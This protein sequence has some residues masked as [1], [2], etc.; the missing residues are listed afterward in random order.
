MRTLLLAGLFV[1]M[2]LAGCTG[3][4]LD[5]PDEYGP[6]F[7]EMYKEVAEKL[8]EAGTPI[9]DADY[10]C[11]GDVI[12]EAYGTDPN[13]AASYPTLEQLAEGAGNL[14][15]LGNTTAPTPAPVFAWQATS[16]AGDFTTTAAYDAESFTQ[17]RSFTVPAG[18]TDLWFN[19][20][21]SGNLPGGVNV[22]YVPPG[23][24]SAD[25][26]VEDSASGGS[27]ATRVDDFTAGEWNLVLFS[28][29]G[30]QT[31]SYDLEVNALLPVA[32]AIPGAPT[33]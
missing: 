12:E 31:G 32:P 6:Q 27:S 3:K 5:C 2:A 30:A 1:T 20:T 26:F 28:S 11:I 25:C 19:L 23:C 24:T 22:R 33:A 21:I 7:E 10:D 29:L 15:G 13:D 4:T 9:E 8:D 18:A 17:G 14:P 16:F